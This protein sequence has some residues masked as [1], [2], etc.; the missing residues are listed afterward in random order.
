M[1]HKKPQ[2][3][4]FFL[5]DADEYKTISELK[6][7]C[8][9]LEKKLAEALKY[10]N[11]AAS[12][13]ESH[14]HAKIGTLE[15]ELK[16]HRSQK[17]S[18]EIYQPESQEQVGSGN[19]THNE[20]ECTSISLQNSVNSGSEDKSIESHQ[21][22]L[23]QASNDA[24]FR[25]TLVTAFERFLK[26]QTCNVNS[27]STLK[28]DQS[29]SG[30]TEDLTPTLPIPTTD[31]QAQT[32]PGQSVEDEVKSPQTNNTNNESGNSNEQLLLSVPS[33]S[34]AKATKLLSELRNFESDFS[35]DTSGSITLNGTTLPN[36]SFYDLF[37]LLFKR[38]EKKRPKDSPLSLV[39]NELIS[40]G[41]GHLINRSFSA[42]LLPR[43]QKYLKDRESVRKNLK[44]NWYYLGK[45][46]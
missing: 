27:P 45:D 2:T 37:P 31:N 15:E 42:G 4:S 30:V 13:H 11:L 43:G 29:G 40:L 12:A 14:L 19:T 44:G 32:L 22:T 16:K 3:E 17:V 25:K 8:S 9:E 26:T 34:R 24:E 38:Q 36:T 7:K 18:S 5:I 35:Y 33:A 23:L 1:S 6:E 21:Q 28:I 39:V 20:N 10:K 41:L 46:D